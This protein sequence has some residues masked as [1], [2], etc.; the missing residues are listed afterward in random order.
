MNEGDIE[1]FSDKIKQKMCQQQNYLKSW[2]KE[3]IKITKE[4]EKES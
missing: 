2:L 4:Y 3:V 1:T